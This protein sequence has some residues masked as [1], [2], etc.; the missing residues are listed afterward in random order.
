MPVSVSVR[1]PGRAE[2][3]SVTPALSFTTSAVFPMPPGSLKVAS[4]MLCPLRPGAKVMVSAPGRAAAVASAS[5][6]EPG[7][8][9]AVVVTSSAVERVRS[10][11]I[12]FPVLKAL[13]FPSLLGL[14]ARTSRSTAPALETALFWS[15]LRQKNLPLPG[16]GLM[17][18]TQ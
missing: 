18:T 2:A 17:T 16:W 12:P 14:F 9:S 3:S 8:E 7:P 5:R 1:P 15:V 4:A 6:R 13:Q 11:R 10:W